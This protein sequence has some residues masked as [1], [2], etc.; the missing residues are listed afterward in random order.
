MC[1]LVSTDVINWKAEMHRVP[2]SHQKFLMSS[3]DAAAHRIITGE[4]L[5]TTAS[6]S[7][8]P[9]AGAASSAPAMGPPRGAT[10]PPPLRLR[11]LTSRGG[12]GEVPRQK[13]GGRGASSSSARGPRG[14]PAGAS[15]AV[16]LG[17][18]SAWLGAPSRSALRGAA[19]RSWG[20]P[21][22]W[23]SAL[24]APRPKA[25]GRVGARSSKQQ[26][27][28]S[29]KQPSSSERQPSRSRRA[30]PRSS[31]AEAA[32]QPQEARTRRGASWGSSRVAN[33][34]GPWELCE[35]EV[36]ARSSPGLRAERL[37]AG[38][39]ELRGADGLGQEPA[40]AP[41]SWAP[42]AP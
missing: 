18:R 26:P 40:G 6:G 8:S 15:S 37:R 22:A 20:L 16:A 4:R 31:R 32:E 9:G 24:G 14:L 2:E 41:S 11:R 7:G 42:G 17:A 39:R 30:A 35:P 12:G 19:R 21:G 34:S 23:R 36:R 27:S 25:G 13:P 5:V 28:S 38:G 3:A 33:L 1:H 29:K 10:P